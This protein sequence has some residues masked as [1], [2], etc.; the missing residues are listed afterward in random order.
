MKIEYAKW[1]NSLAVRIPKALADEIGA[2]EGKAAEI[3]IE[4]GALVLRPIV[5]KRRP[6]RLEDLL[7]GMTVEQAHDIVEWGLDL[8]TEAW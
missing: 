6:Y 2:R 1:G 5:R 8:G 7:K 3:T 4:D